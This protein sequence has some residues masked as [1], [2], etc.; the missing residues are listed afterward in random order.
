MTSFAVANEGKMSPLKWGWYWALYS[1]IFLKW[2]LWISTCISA[3]SEEA[4]FARIEVGSP[5]GPRPLRNF[6]DAFSLSHRTSYIRSDIMHREV[7]WLVREDGKATR[8]THC[9]SIISSAIDQMRSLEMYWNPREKFQLDNSGW[10]ISGVLE[11]CLA[12][13]KLSASRIRN[14]L[15]KVRDQVWNTSR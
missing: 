10:T 11:R 9:R 3:S 13:R 4:I 5:R 14:H 15:H 6:G 2:D 7:S 1:I 12:Q 8:I